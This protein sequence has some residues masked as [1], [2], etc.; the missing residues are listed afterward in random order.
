MPESDLCMLSFSAEVRMLLHALYRVMHVEQLVR[1]WR[2][3]HR[4][5]GG[6]EASCVCKNVV[7]ALPDNY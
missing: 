1:L 6:I 4:A 2:W 5:H 3:G 7:K